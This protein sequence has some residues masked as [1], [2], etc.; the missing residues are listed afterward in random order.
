[1]LRDVLVLA[2]F[3]WGLY[4]SLRAPFYALMLYL[5]IAHFRPQSWAWAGWLHDIPMSLIAAILVFG[6]TLLAHRRYTMNPLQMFMIL[7]CIMGAVSA[8]YSLAPD[9]SWRWY[10]DFLK[11]VA[12]T[13]VLSILVDDLHKFRVAGLVI[14]FSLGAEAAKQGLVGMILHPGGKNSN[15][16]PHLG[17]NNGVGLGMVILFAIIVGLYQASTERWQRV[18]LALLGTGVLLRGV[19]TYSRGAFLTLA[20]L[21][22][23][24]WLQ[25]KRKF[26]NALVVV[27]AV[28]AFMSVMPESY[29]QR[30]DT[31]SEVFEE[32]GVQEASAASR[33]YMWGLAVEMANDYPFTGVGFNAY[34]NAYSSYDTMGGRFG[35][36]RSAHGSIPGVLADTGYIGAILYVSVFLTALLYTMRIKRLAQFLE[37]GAEIHIYATALQ[38]ALICFLVG[39]AFLSYM[40]YE[41]V[42]HVLGLTAALGLITK[43]LMVE[44]VREGWQAAAQERAEP[45]MAPGKVAYR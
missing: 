45:E 3:V 42:W 36:N 17:D 32:E 11:V 35:L 20:V 2:V 31:I 4:M 9:Q 41:I 23:L 39:G 33:I 25:E 40:Y 6:Y 12:V 34:G 43:S 1:M 44:Q 24:L 8:Y 27:A 7:F 38:N 22:L 5:W 29:F 28:M 19:T 26:R 16:I 18:L 21:S 15:A 14:A 10:P 30:M 13:Y 37:R